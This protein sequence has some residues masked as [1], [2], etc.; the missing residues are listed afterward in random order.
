MSTVFENVLSR[1]HPE[2]RDRVKPEVVEA[3]ER[4]HEVSFEYRIVTDDGEVRV[5]RSYGE[6]E[7]DG[8]GRVVALEGTLQDITEL[9]NQRLALSRS[10]EDL[11]RLNARLAHT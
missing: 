9:Y 2:D 1:I 11:R 10:R 3:I 4:G 8:D 6:P 5:I 7:F